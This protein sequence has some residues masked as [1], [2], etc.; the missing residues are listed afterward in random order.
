MHAH[1]VV[2]TT[3]TAEDQPQ[4]PELDE[5]DDM[6]ASLIIEE[7]CGT[8]TSWVHPHNGYY[9]GDFS[10]VAPTTQSQLDALTTVRRD[11]TQPQPHH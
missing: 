10:N 9:A 7:E 11:A 5:V 2:N 4:P 8:W 6:A 3:R 1:S